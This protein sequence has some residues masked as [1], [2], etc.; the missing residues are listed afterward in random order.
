VRHDRERADETHDLAGHLI[1]A[2]LADHIRVADAGE[3]LDFGRDGPAGVE[4]GAEF[5]G[6][7]AI[8]EFDRADL[9]DRVGAG[10]QTGGF[11]VQGNISAGYSVSVS[12]LPA[13]ARRAG[14]LAGLGLASGSAE[15]L[16]NRGP[17]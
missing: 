14:T 15:T 2:R 5:V 4:Q 17:S 11:Q 8:P 6:R 13:R 9:D 16:Y 10:I 1:E 12:T 3:E 7:L